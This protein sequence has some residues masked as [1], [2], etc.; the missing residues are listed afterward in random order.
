MLRELIITALLATGTAQG[1][2]FELRLVSPCGASDKP[3]TLEGTTH[4]ICLAP[5]KVLDQSAIVRAQR[6]PMINRVIVDI[7]PAASDKLLAVSTA[8]VG[9]ELAVLFQDKLIFKA[10]ITEPLK[11]EKFQLSLNNAPD[12]VDALVAAFPGAAQ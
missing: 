11:L 12:T 9:Q 6:Y 5:D 7:T 2:V 8:N 3:Y 4:E 1:A 10:P